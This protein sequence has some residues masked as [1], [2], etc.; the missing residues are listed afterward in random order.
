MVLTTKEA[1]YIIA[2]GI[3]I[4]VLP[5]SPTK[6]TVVPATCHYS[7]E[8]TSKRTCSYSICKPTILN[9]VKATWNPDTIPDRAKVQQHNPTDIQPLITKYKQHGCQADYRA[10]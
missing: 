10:L 3:V 1:S 2:L 5:I 6:P 8:S 7:C 9:D 4:S